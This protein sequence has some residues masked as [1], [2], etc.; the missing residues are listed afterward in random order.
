MIEFFKKV[1]NLFI[2]E[3]RKIEKLLKLSQSELRNALQRTEPIKEKDTFPIFDYRNKN[4]SSLIWALKYRRHPEILWRI[5]KFLY[6]E[7]MELGE[8]RLLFEGKSEMALIPIPIGSRSRRERGFNQTEELAKAISKVSNG[9]IKILNI[10]EKIKE[11]RN[12]TRLSREDRLQNMLETMKT[13]DFFL[14]K[15][16]L[17]ILLDDVYTTGA[18]IKEARRALALAGIKDV[19]AVKIAH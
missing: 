19:L 12:Q 7:I 4:T 10:L 18:T 5:A 3:D 16:I 13:K 9:E 11:T 1:V 17:P 8:E 6:E 15:D 14:S 2:P